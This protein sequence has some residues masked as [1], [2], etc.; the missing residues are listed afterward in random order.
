MD[1]AFI[2]PKQWFS[3]EEACTLKGLNYKTSCNK[4]Y[5]QPNGGKSEAKIGGRKKYSRATVINWLTLTDENLI[6]INN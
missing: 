4:T 5:L 1:Q 2:P 3:L 6:P